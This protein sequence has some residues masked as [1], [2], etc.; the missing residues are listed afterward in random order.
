M[1]LAVLGVIAG[2]MTLGD[3]VMVNAYLVQLYMPLNFLGFAYREIKQGL[4]DMEQM[5]RLLGVPQEVEDK[6]GAP[7]LQASRG[8]L[9][10]SEE[11]TSELQ[12]LMRTSYVVFCLT[13]KNPKH[14]NTRTN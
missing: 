9:V 11:H 1:S 10:R 5:F 13:N 4:V 8:E 3:V 6:P 2:T 7:A 14:I 12:S